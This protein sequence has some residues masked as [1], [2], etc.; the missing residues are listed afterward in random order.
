M[1]E[2]TKKVGPQIVKN[3]APKVVKTLTPWWLQFFYSIFGDPIK[4]KMMATSSIV[5]DGPHTTSDA[6][7][8]I[9]F[10]FFLKKKRIKFHFLF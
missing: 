10:V 9:F 6:V 2:V 7:V 1:F 3:V 4:E 5:P 8:C